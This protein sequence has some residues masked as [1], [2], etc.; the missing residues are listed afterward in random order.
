M[1]M[2][3]SLDNPLSA[4]AEALRAAKIAADLTLR[5][6]SPKIIGVASALPGEGK[7]TISANFACLLAHLGYRTLL[8]DADLRNPGLTR[9][10]APE[11][12]NGI[13]EAVLDGRPIRDMLLWHQD[14]SLAVLPAAVRGRVPHT[15]EFL[16]SPGMKSVLK[17]AEQ[18]FAFIVVDLPPLAPVVDVRA[19]APMLDAILLDRGVG[20]DDAFFPPHNLDAGPHGSRQVPWG[21]VEQGQAGQAEA[22]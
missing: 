13:V 11:A 3:Y 8:I 21:A 5:D 6:R 22:V 2:R 7:S 20:R 15:S 9:A 14:T 16:A 12:E 19:I 10:I 4:F 1:L 18:E 17:Q